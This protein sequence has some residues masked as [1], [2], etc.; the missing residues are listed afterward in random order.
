MEQIQLHPDIG[1]CCADSAYF[2]GSFPYCFHPQTHL[3]LPVKEPS[4]FSA[5]ENAALCRRCGFSIPT[6]STVYRRSLF[7]QYGGYQPE[8]A[9]L[10]N[11]YSDVQILL[12]HPMA[13]IPETCGAIRIRQDSYGQMI[14]TNIAK[15]VRATSAL[16]RR[17]LKEDPLFRRAMRTSGLLFNTGWFALPLLAAKPRL[18][19]FLPG[20]FYQQARRLR[21]YFIRF[22]QPTAKK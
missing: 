10:C 5:Q 12:R 15:R 3:H 17:V 7:L 20:F 8:F 6:N 11:F 19:P 13:Y 18:W 4:Y 16:L 22:L 1:L 14:R 2:S 21:T 9:S